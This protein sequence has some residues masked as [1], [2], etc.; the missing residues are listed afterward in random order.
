MRW[1]ESLQLR[2]ALPRMAADFLLIHSS[3]AASMAIAI[4]YHALTA[5]AIAAGKVA[6]LLTAYYAKLFGPLSLLF[7]IVFLLNGFYTRTRTYS[8]RDKAVVVARGVAFGILIFLAANFLLFREALVPRS[9]V[10]S[11]CVLATASLTGVRFLKTALIDRFDIRPRTSV[12]PESSGAILVVGGAGYIGSILLRKL[13]AQGKRVRVLDNLVYGDGALREILAHP[14]LE[15]ID[16]DCRNIQHVVSAVKG[17]D[18]IVHLAAIVGD[19]AC[20]HDRQSALEVNYAA[21]RMLIEIAKGNAVR[22]FVFASSCSVYGATDV[23][24]DEQSAVSP[25]SLYAQTKID[26]ER[27]LLEARSGSFHPVILRL[28]TVF[29]HSYRPRF[30]LVVNLLSAKAHQ[31][32]VI[33]VFNG[34][35][36]RP[37]IHVD[38]VAEGILAVLRAPI[39]LVTGQVY[40]LGDSRQN[41]TLAEVARKIQE[42]FPAT[43]VDSVENSDRRNYRV[44]FDK[45]RRQVGFEC[46]IDLTPG[47][48]ELRSALEAGLPASYTDPRYNNHKSL[49]FGGRNAVLDQTSVRVMAAFAGIDPGAPGIP[50]RPA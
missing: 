12:R 42:V 19:P 39:E 46:K 23:L 8:R 36:W 18:A 6:Q 9:V 14:S 34:E 21:T 49:Q 44:S 40:N 48:V 25:V 22:R 4:I 24:M 35:Q 3:M 13:L 17:V 11:F 15:L 1:T 26:S 10:L 47:I 41:Y 7:P 31:E 16:G 30:D 38:D 28:A 33:T 50:P 2:Q 20:E 29:G 32:G 45:I 27:A 37:F 5:E 43:R